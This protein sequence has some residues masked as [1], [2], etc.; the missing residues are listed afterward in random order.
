MK[1]S[2]ESAW[3]A[4]LILLVGVNVYWIGYDLWAHYTNHYT[5]T[6][7]MQNWLHG[8]VS[9]PLIFGFLGFIVL[10]FYYHMLQRAAS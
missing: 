8:A 7:Q 9:G 5:M 6:K 2:S 3:L 4:W 1:T 10:A